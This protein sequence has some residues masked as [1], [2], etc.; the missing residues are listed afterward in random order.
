[1]LPLVG[2]LHRAAQT[3]EGG[4]GMGTRVPALLESLSK[5]SASAPGQARLDG[6]SFEVAL[7]G[8]SARKW[9]LAGRFLHNGV[10]VGER[11]LLIR[12]GSLQLEGG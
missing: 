4:V 1:M 8:T 12:Y 6:F 5:L 9:Q 10:D 3:G 2:V 7:L 11:D